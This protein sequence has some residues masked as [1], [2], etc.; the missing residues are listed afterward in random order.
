MESI[1]NFFSNIS[2]YVTAI[3]GIVLA[4]IALFLLIPGDQPEKTLK[5]IA[6]ILGKISK[7]KAEQ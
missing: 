1:I 5:T 6:D 7:K 2:V 3:N 4:L